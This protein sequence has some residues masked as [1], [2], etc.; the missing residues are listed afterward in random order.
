MKK[1]L[2]GL[3]LIAFPVIAMAQGNS[4]VN[5]NPGAVPVLDANHM[6]QLAKINS[7]LEQINQKLDGQKNTDPYKFCYADDKAFSEDA[8]HAGRT[9]RRSSS[10][11]MNGEDDSRN[12][13]YSLVWK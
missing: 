5:S 12:I 3:V 4:V 7:N 9:C 1:T 11:V 8:I 13:K 2:Y 6:M 10:M